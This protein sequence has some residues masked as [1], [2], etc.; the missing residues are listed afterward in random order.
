MLKDGNAA[1]T[2]PLQTVLPQDADGDDEELTI[3][4]AHVAGCYVALRLADGTA[5][6][7]HF[8]PGALSTMHTLQSPSHMPLCT[9]FC[10]YLVILSTQIDG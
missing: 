5:I 9:R 2:L 10:P 8:S 3:D 7:L 1:Q 4:A 6:V